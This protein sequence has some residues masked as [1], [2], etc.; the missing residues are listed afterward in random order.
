MEVGN[1]QRTWRSTS[2]RVILAL[3]SLIAAGIAGAAAEPSRPAGDGGNAKPPCPTPAAIETAL[4][5]PVRPVP[6]AV[7]GCLYELTGRYRGVMVSLLYQPA[8]RAN[9]VFADIKRQ[10]KAKGKDAEPDRLRLGDGGWG[11]ASRGKKEAAAVSQGRLYHVEIDHNLFESLKLPDD[12]ALKVI[13]L[14]MRTAPGGTATA[15]S[16]PGTGGATV[17]ACTLASNAEVAQ[18]AEERP[19]I[20]KFWSAPTSSFGGSHCDYDGGSIRVYQGKASA[21]ALESTLK[22]VAA[23]AQRVPVSGI[24][25]KAFF[26]IPY[27][28]DPYKRLG[29]LAVYA[30]PRVVQLTLD[31]NGKEP[32]DATRPR[33]EKLARLVLP[34]VR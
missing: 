10:V 19:E 30:G 22:N 6:V 15:S 13:E 8:T 3:V 1:M 25:D 2:T 4:G 7:D 26:M 23:G 14:G 33:L 5:F 34:R 21:A 18:I 29:L 9:D 17:D 12:A 31:A 20:A 28:N 24:G 11:Y 27:P 16:G 32:L